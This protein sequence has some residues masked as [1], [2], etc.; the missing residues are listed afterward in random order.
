MFPERKRFERSGEAGLLL[1]PA[2]LVRTI[3]PPDDCPVE[4]A[5]L[6]SARGKKNAKG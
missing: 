3:A 1:L 4:V 2:Q 5:I 6:F